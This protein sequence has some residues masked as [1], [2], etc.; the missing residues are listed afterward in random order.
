MTYK[1]HPKVLSHYADISGS[2][3]V[4]DV[5]ASALKQ[6]K[7]DIIFKRV[8]KPCYQLKDYIV[9]DR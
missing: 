3:T 5:D 6:V 9:C 1:V 7:N 8:T 2:S 4:N